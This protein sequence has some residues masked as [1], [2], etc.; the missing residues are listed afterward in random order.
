MGR[1]GLRRE[2]SRRRQDEGGGNIG[3]VMVGK[4]RKTYGK[5]NVCGIY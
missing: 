5:E 4:K 1:K 2:R 3:K